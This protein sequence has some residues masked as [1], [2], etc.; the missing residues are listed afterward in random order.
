M[1]LPPHLY[2]IAVGALWS[3]C[4]TFT[5]FHAAYRPEIYLL[6]L[7]LNPSLLPRV[8][9]LSLYSFVLGNL[10]RLLEIQPNFLSFQNSYSTRVVTHMLC[11]AS[12]VAS[13]AAILVRACTS[14]RRLLRR[15]SVPP[16]HKFPRGTFK[17]RKT[18]TQAS[19]VCKGSSV[20]SRQLRRWNKS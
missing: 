1:V 3:F 9:V 13:P 12:G 18:Q 16:L 19:I 15:R 8:N 7:S 10:E 20:T 14:C 4:L 6:Y 11:I 5:T 17:R 2:H